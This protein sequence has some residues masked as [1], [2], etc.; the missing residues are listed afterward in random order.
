LEK[1]A[2][3]CLENNIII[4]SDDIH[5]DFIYKGFKY[6]PL[7]KINPEIQK[8]TITALSPSKTFNIA[9]L[10]TSVVVIP[11]K[12]LRDKYNEKLHGV[13]LFLGNIFGNIAFETAYNYGESWLNQLIEY[14]ENNVDFAVNYIREKIPQIK[15][16]RPEGTFLLWLDFS[17]TG[18]THEQIKQKLINQAKLGF[19]SGLDFG[20]QGEKFFRMNIAAPK[21]IVEQA[22]KRLETTFS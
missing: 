12:E 19:N 15:V 1:L 9:G 3:I 20:K 8:I 17:Q 18:L 16:W 11:N 7:A 2:Q 14:L 5:S 4:V 10:S 21:A 22:L 13:H 6:T